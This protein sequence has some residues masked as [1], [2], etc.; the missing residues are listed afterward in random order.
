MPRQVKATGPVLYKDLDHG[1]EIQQKDFKYVPKDPNFGFDPEKNR[2]V[3]AETI[4]DN[5]RR[6]QALKKEYLENV[7]EKV[8]AGVYFLKK[9]TTGA[10]ESLT[11]HEAALKYFGSKELARLRGEEIK[12]ELM[13]RMSIKSGII[14]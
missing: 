10:Y 8:D 6:E 14:R 1:G 13:A 2:R 4:A 11:P 12:Q 7:E 3:I 5:K 9:L